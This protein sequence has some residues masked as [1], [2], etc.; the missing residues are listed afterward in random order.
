M[1]RATYQARLSDCAA[2]PF[3]EAPFIEQVRALHTLILPSVEREAAP[4]TQLDGASEIESLEAHIRE[5][6]AAISQYLGAQP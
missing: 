4:Y 2:G 5:R 3:A 6:H 1:Y